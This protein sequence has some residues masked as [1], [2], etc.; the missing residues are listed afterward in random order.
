VSKVTKRPPVHPGRILKSEL[1]EAGVTANAAALA[2]RIPSNRLTAIVNGKRSVS[3][4]TAMRLGR[5]FGTSAQMWINL[6]AQYD[7]QMAEDLLAEKIE[8]EVEPLKVA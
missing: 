6:Q 4:D 2:L 7:L 1:A 3:A 5:Y 8:R